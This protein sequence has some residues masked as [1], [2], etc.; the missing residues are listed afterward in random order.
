MNTSRPVFAL[1]GLIS[2]A[3]PALAAEPT[4]EQLDFFESKIRP[5]LA[6]NCYSCHSIEQGKSKGG[7]TLDTVDASR[8]GGDTGA[9]VVPGD[10]EKSLLYKAMTY[11]DKELQMPPKSKG[12][13]LNDTEIAAI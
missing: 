8:K 6:N 13:K 2:A 3:L 1:A 11:T 9:A 5:I 12:G 4:K 7:L 10:V